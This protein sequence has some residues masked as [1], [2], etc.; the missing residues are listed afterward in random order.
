MKK[1]TN[2]T[3]K[4]H[5]LRSAFYLL[6]LLAVCA[7]PFALAQRNTKTST[8][9]YRA[10]ILPRISQIPL[11]DSGTLA[12]HIVTAPPAPQAPQVILYDQ[13]DNAG[14]NAT[15]SQDFEVSLDAFDDELADDFV[16]PGGQ[17]W[18]VESIDA[19]G[20]YFNGFG[21]AQNFNVRFYNNAGGLPGALVASRIGSTYVQG[22]TTFSIT[23]S[24]AVSLAA[25]TYWVSVQARQDFTP[26]GQ[27]GWTDRTVQS[28]SAAAWQNPGGGFGV[29][30]TWGQRGATCGID[31]GVPDQ[32][33]RLNGTTGGGT[34]TP[35]PTATP[36]ATPGGCQF[37]V[38]IVYSDI[39]GLPTMIQNEILAE[40][41]VTT[42]DLFDAFSG[43]PTLAQLQQYNIVYAFSN[44]GWFDAVAMG[45]VLAD[46]QDAGGV[47]VVSTFA[48]DNRGPWL[49]Q[50]RWATGGYSPYDS[51]STTLFST[52][53]ATITD[54]SHP[55][56]Q[57]VSSLTAFYRNGVTLASGAVAQAVWTDGP[58]AVAYKVNNGT[59]GVGLNAYLGYLNQFSGE[60][61]RVIVNAGRWLVNCQNIELRARKDRVHGRVVVRLKW[62]GATSDNV[63][64]YRNGVLIATVPNSNGSWTDLLD[65]SGT[66]TYK[67]CNAGTMSCSNEVS[68]TIP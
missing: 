13:Y 54:P 65:S 56:M 63:D 29:C 46:Y 61:G 67:V 51:T 4:A 66:Y 31:N 14:T 16:V 60:W 49:L 5:L 20:V 68:V 9:A 52:N 28:N 45:D 17:S 58:P 44:N 62:R 38:L 8:A 27:W 10:P 19:D 40:P 22:G 11:R 3:M 6:L 33:F 24:P 2:S 21:P 53:T 41:D 37:Q 64:I 59:T 18:S 25:G 43:T 12:A 23:L 50:G 39:G 1:Q 15:S 30:T 36:T 7:I 35:T 55:L 26:A 42:V 48:W 34:P 32:V 57:G 47:V